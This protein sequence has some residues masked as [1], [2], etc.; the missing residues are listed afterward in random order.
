GVEPGWRCLELGAGGGSV[1]RLLCDRVGPE[2]RVAAVDLD[3]RFVEEIEA[4]NLEVHRRDLVAEGLPGDAYD[5]IH[6]RM[7]LMHI[8][9]REKIL[10]E[11]A[12]ALRPGG[13]LLIEDMDVFPLPV[14]AEGV[15]ND[16]WTVGIAAFEAA[17]VC[18][19]FGREL[20]ALFDR[21][22]LEDVE[23]VCEVPTCRGGSP[24]ANL[25]VTSVEQLRPL[26]AT[27]GLT[28][29]QFAELG[30]QMGDPTR[31][32]SA[33]AVYSVRGRTPAA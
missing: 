23:V 17:Q 12:A 11:M 30:R 32:F 33:F 5:L 26:L 10:E 16:V 25:L 29:E 22:G 24:F 1:T 4:G 18:P 21:A 31:W 2:G 8:P 20:P 27:M 19:T 28:D 3:T 6:A 14:L 7:L 15:V 13:W 9:T